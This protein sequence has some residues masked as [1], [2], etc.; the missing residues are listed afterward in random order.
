M[1]KM[2][3]TASDGQAIMDLVLTEA[4]PEFHYLKKPGCRVFHPSDAPQVTITKTGEVS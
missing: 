3:V 1:K 4:D 2:P